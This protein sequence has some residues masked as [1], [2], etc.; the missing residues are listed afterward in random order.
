MKGQLSAEMLLLIVVIIAIVAIA[1]SQLIS[2]AKKT[3]NVI[4][5]KTTQIIESADEAVKGDIGDPC[6][7]SKECKPG[8]TC[9]AGVCTE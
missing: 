2:S 6:I 1:A 5:E 3:S 4:Q 9:E 7:S 8:L